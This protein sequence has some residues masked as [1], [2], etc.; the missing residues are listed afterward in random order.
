M[1]RYFSGL[2]S[3]NRNIGKLGSLMVL[4]GLLGVVKNIIV[5]QTFGTSREIEIYFASIVLF[6]SVERLFS[7]GVLN[8][9]LIPEFVK[10]KEEENN[11][12]AM[13]SFSL[14]NNWIIL[15]STL[16]TI[17]L[18]LFAQNILNIILVG[19][20]ADEI[21]KATYFFRLIIPCMPLRM[22]N[23]MCSVPFMANK[24]YTIHERTGI[25][26][27]MIEIALLTS[28]GNT[29]GV[30]VLIYAIIIGVLIR[31]SFILYLFKKYNYYYKIM[32]RSKRF[33]VKWIFSKIYIPL[34]QTFGLQINR[35]IL[36]GVLTLL[37]QG[38][39]AIYQ[40]VEKFSG[41]I[42]SIFMKSFSSIFL[43]ETSTES[44][45]FDK[46][47]FNSFLEKILFMYF[48]ILIVLV[49]AGNDILTL[50]WQSDKFTTDNISLAYMLLMF[51][52]TMFFFQIIG[53]AYI[54]L[55]TARGY[56]AKHY[57]SGLVMQIISSIVLVLTI[58]PLGFYSLIVRLLI[59]S[60]T[61]STLSIYFNYRNNK[62]S[63]VI[64][65]RN[66]IVKSFFQ[67]LITVLIIHYLSWLTPFNAVGEDK[68]FTLIVI[69]VKTFTSLILFATVN[70]YIKV[71]NIKS[72]L[73]S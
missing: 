43:T 64:F 38:M 7:I 67:I 2:S 14:L 39:L 21:N 1:P 8:D 44:N 55:D 33:S 25:L 40:Y 18:W 51:F 32:L 59:I 26:N 30:E 50:L 66:Y 15:V 49:C 13:I 69:L 23:G 68:L 35:W 65:S 57:I 6:L 12:V 41:Q 52:T 19:F 47:W 29:Y 3:F 70:R 24:I 45:L 11:D 4:V 31:F 20:N 63:F 73:K 22:F 27:K 9:I 37:P 28:L 53:M 48:I 36:Y 10:L 72:I 46:N 34:A 61:T 5:V 56:I 16:V 60:F 54:K 42:S 62:E 58:E 17:I 71:H